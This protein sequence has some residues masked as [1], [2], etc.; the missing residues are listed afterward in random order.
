MSRARSVFVHRVLL[1]AIAWALAPADAQVFPKQLTAPPAEVLSGARDLP[2]PALTGVDS[3]SAMLPI[4]FERAGAGWVWRG[5]APIDDPRE[6][7]AMLVG[8]GA[9]AWRVRATPPGG[10]EI[11]LDRAGEAVLV[12]PGA[13]DLGALQPPARQSRVYGQPGGVW[14]FRVEAP[15]DA[16]RGL[17]TEG[18]LLLRTASES[19]LRSSL[20]T[21]RLLVGAEVGVDAAM[22]AGAVLESARALLRAPGAVE[23]ALPMLVD[24][25]AARFRFVPT[26]AGEHTVHIIVRGRHADGARFVRTSQHAFPVLEDTLGLGAEAV[27]ES[28][29]PDARRVHLPLDR[30]AAPARLI[31]AAEVWGVDA[32]GQP[33]P[34]CWLGQIT[35]VAPG[36]AAVA[37]HLDERWLALAAAEGVGA[38]LT[39]RGVR[40]QDADTGI[41]FATARALPVRTDG[42]VRA[43]RAPPERIT[44]DMLMGR[45]RP[46]LA[47][48]ARDGASS[49][50]RPRAFAGHNLMLVHGYC[51]QGV[52]P[53]AQFTGGGAGGVEVF[54]D[55]NQSRSH[56]QFASLLLDFGSTSKSFGIVAHSQGGA[57]ALHLLTFYFSG[58]DWA[59]GPRLIQSVGTPYQGTPLAG[60]LAVLGQLFGTGCGTNFDLSVDGAALW[61]ANIPASS[62]QRVHYWTTSFTDDG[63]FDYCNLVSDFFLAD[64]D[65]GV[66][67]RSR[68]QLPGAVNMGHT[69][70]WCHSA[71]MRDPPH[72]LDAAR[73]AEINGS[74]AR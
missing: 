34:V 42:P 27:L 48:P 44:P 26:Q 12:E 71:G 47:L 20:S 29:D 51:S 50:A 24:G 65:D 55:A 64:P 16:A 21:H 49:A 39:L 32:R 14:T 2:D 11:D 18:Y 72:Y 57:A 23:R 67:E 63:G 45:P 19:A 6:V 35:E 68:G 1:A 46:D 60:N 53:A 37:L 43:R 31:A 74:A 38:P 58:L 36:D 52:W 22:P 4:R 54:L 15:A 66:I 13:L 56:D 69:E 28:A 5:E 40:L 25:H 8:P 73:N 30:V 9:E 10:R 59:E 41:P 17:P 7:R 70:G 61:L 3:R 33:H 62:R